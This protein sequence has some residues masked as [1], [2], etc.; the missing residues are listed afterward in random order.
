M[1][2]AI[3]RIGKSRGLRTPQALIE[4]CGIGDTVELSVEDGRLIVQP[5]VA[6]RAG[7]VEA[8]RAMA[9]RGDDCLLNSETP[10][11]FDDSAWEW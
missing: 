6:V 5:V 10:T 3:I 2:A 8:A 4:E 9:E 11:S 1:R 7:W